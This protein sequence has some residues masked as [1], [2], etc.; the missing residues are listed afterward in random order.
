MVIV[1]KK[2]LKQEKLQAYRSS[3]LHG[4]KYVRH[5]DGAEIQ[6]SI[7]MMTDSRSLTDFIQRQA[8]KNLAHPLIGWDKELFDENLIEEIRCFN[9]NVS[10]AGESHVRN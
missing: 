9:I 8:A 7:T 5:F 2:H 10:L 1:K 4:K 6:I 3:Y